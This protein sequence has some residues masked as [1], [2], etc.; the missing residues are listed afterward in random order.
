MIGG[1]R[2]TRYTLASPANRPSN[3]CRTGHPENSSP[4][5]VATSSLPNESALPAT[6]SADTSKVS[7]VR[8]RTNSAPGHTDRDDKEHVGRL[9]VSKTSVLSPS[10]ALALTTAG[11]EDH[12]FAGAFSHAAELSHALSPPGPG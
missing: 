12:H 3:V 1:T 5:K 2:S 4:P 6:C 9:A 11:V 7:L 8:G 10:S